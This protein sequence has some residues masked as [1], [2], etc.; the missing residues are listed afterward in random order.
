MF[1]RL[2]VL[3]LLFDWVVLQDHVSLI[4][5]VMGGAHGSAASSAGPEGTTQNLGLVAA[6]LI[7]LVLCHVE[8]A[9]AHVPSEGKSGTNDDC[10]SP[11]LAQAAAAASGSSLPSSSSSSFF[12]PVEAEGLRRR[13]RMPGPLRFLVDQYVAFASSGH[14]WG[15]TE[16]LSLQLQRALAGLPF[17]E[18]AVGVGVGSV[19]DAASVPPSALVAVM[20]ETLRLMD[21]TDNDALVD[22]LIKSVKELAKAEASWAA[23]SDG[24]VKTATAVSFMRADT[25]SDH[26]AVVAGLSL[27]WLRLLILIYGAL[28]V[29]ASSSSSA[30]SSAAS[31][32]SS[33]SASAASKDG[34]SGS[35]QPS[36]SPSDCDFSEFLSATRDD[37]SAVSSPSKLMPADLFN[38]SSLTA[39]Q[40]LACFL[41]G[42]AYAVFLGKSGCPFGATKDIRNRAILEMDVALLESLRPPPPSSSSA[43]SS[44]SSTKGSKST[45]VAD[46]FTKAL[47]VSSELFAIGRKAKAAS[48]RKKGGRDE[49]VDDD[50]DDEND[51]DDPILSALSNELPCAKAEVEAS[52]QRVAALSQASSSSPNAALFAADAVAQLPKGRG[53]PT[54]EA[55]ERKAAFWR[56]A[57]GEKHALLAI[58][59]AVTAC[60]LCLARY[61]RHDVATLAVISHR[62]QLLADVVAARV[63]QR[64]ARATAW[65][66]CRARYSAQELASALE[67]IRVIATAA[68]RWAVANCLAGLNA[69]SSAAASSSSSSSSSSS[70]T[71]SSALALTASFRNNMSIDFHATVGLDCSLGSLFFP[72]GV[73]VASFPDAATEQLVLARPLYRP[74]ARAEAKGSAGGKR[75]RGGRGRGGRGRGGRPRQPAEGNGSASGSD[76]DENSDPDADPDRESTSK[77]DSDG[78]PEAQ[79]VFVGDDNDDDDNDDDDDAGDALLPRRPRLPSDSED[80]LGV[81]GFVDAARTS[82][83]LASASPSSS[84]PAPQPAPQP[85]DHATSSS[86]STA[87]ASALVGQVAGSKRPQRPEAA[88][89]GDAAAAESPKRRKLEA[90]V[91]QSSKDEGHKQAVSAAAK[92]NLDGDDSDDDDACISSNDS[93]SSSSE[94]SDADSSSSES[95]SDSSSSDGSDSYASS[96]TSSSSSSSSSD[97]DSD[98]D[99]NSFTSASSPVIIDGEGAKADGGS[100]DVPEGNENLV[101]LED[102]SF[103]RRRAKNQKKR[104]PSR[105]SLL[106]LKTG[107]ASK[108]KAGGDEA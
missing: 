108:P 34:S 58:L 89:G 90:N 27:S 42:A 64:G 78:K 33:S 49:N 17:L 38:F 28:S 97:G 71:A 83:K 75:G 63:Q 55:L 59:D 87:S 67:D 61:W 53:R 86:S 96:S 7:R 94:D 43:S 1:A 106:L 82:S 3:R 18:T 57:E 100:N 22:G 15:N 91:S 30:I 88:S 103:R 21:A 93:A 79:E 11:L 2:R 69:G 5:R 13:A 77:S 74:S 26:A 66:H 23:S 29:P 102:G 81:S 76:S 99:T 73:A 68:G 48:K 9:S 14:F 54:A 104:K 8:A 4:A 25:A 36:L 46:A 50:T 51:D 35:R 101:E 40:K 41:F 92:M 95:S 19:A 80:P 98:S 70:P 32:A 20:R 105:K 52:C 60:N 72:S 44:S 6:D 16:K 56:A 85:A 31:S 45:S 62:R 84:Q 39:D 107:S 65:R 24:F 12:T 37:G 10:Y 47:A